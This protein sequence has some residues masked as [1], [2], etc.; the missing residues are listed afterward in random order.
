MT[1]L[2]ER[3]SGSGMESVAAERDVY[4]P[5]RRLEARPKAAPLDEYDPSLSERAP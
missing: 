1:H 4:D 5:W 3:G 2:E